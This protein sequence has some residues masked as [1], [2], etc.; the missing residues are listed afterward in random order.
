MGTLD[1]MIIYGIWPI[2]PNDPIDSLRVSQALEGSGVDWF[3]KNESILCRVTDMIKIW[4]QGEL[5][6]NQVFRK[7]STGL[8]FSRNFDIT[9]YSPGSAHI[10]VLGL[11]TIDM[12]RGKISNWTGFKDET[13]VRNIMKEFFDY[14][15][16]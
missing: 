9:I 8:V 3:P 15:G 16:L 10:K 6:L 1:Q 7:T 14:R 12:K 4:D 13:A 2:D 11:G 5:K